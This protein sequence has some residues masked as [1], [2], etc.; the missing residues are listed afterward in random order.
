MT[1]GIKTGG[2]KVSTKNNLTGNTNE[3]ITQVHTQEL[4]KLPVLV[5][6]LESKERFDIIFKLLPFILPRILP[7][8]EPKKEVPKNLHRLMNS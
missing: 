5:D 7:V 2:R 1:K 8:E 3:M 6:Q 4:Q